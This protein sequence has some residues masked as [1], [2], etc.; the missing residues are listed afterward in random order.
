MPSTVEYATPNVYADQIE[1]FCKH[2]SNRENVI[3]STHCHNDRG[4][5]V[6]ACELALLA[7]ADRVEGCLFGNGE[8][9][10]NLDIITTALNMYTH[11]VDTGLIFQIAGNYS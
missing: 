4:T 1:Y 5:G 7:G 8:R 9:T 3:V 6:A 10:G 11:G 2:I